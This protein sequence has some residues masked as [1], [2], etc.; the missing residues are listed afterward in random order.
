MMMM[1]M[2]LKRMG[3]SVLITNFSGLSLFSAGKKT[4]LI[5]RI[6]KFV[7]TGKVAEKKGKKKGTTPAGAKRKRAEKDEEE[8]EDEN[9]VETKQEAAKTGEE[10]EEEAEA[11]AEEMTNEKKGIHMCRGQR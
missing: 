10:E 7:E 9:G 1:M 4:I 6:V 11:E 2:M 8:G 3:C 5:N